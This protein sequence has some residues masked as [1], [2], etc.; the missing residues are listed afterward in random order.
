MAIS[1]QSSRVLLG[2]YHLSLVATDVKP[3]YDVT[4]LPTSTLASGAK[5]FIPGQTTSQVSIK[6]LMDVSASAGGM[7]DT[8]INWTSN[9]PYAFAPS[10][11]AIGNEVELGSAL[12][13]SFTPSAQVA[14]TVMF[15]IGAQ[16]DGILDLGLSLHDL[17]AES[18]STNSTAV[19]SGAGTS[20]GAV[21]QL[22]V[23][24]YSGLTNAVIKVQHSTDNITFGDL[25]TFSTVTGTTAERPA[26]VA[27]TVNRYVRAISTLS[28]VGSIT[29]Q[30][31][32]DRR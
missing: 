3:S 26:A 19:D 5:T 2:A 31:G 25:I 15:D 13:A 4:M 11:W 14:S 20:N 18:T 8:V 24:A 27:G 22:H 9:T 21:G 12:R 10:G 29:F 17:T 30:V 16:V 1:A 28:G 23:T 32:F 7:F 6:G